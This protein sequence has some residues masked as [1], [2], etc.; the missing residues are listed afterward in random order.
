MADGVSPRVRRRTGEKGIAPA[1]AAGG[2]RFLVAAG[3][4]RQ[5]GGMSEALFVAVA[6]VDEIPPGKVKAVE[7]GGR[8][9]LLCHEEGRIHAIENRCSHAEM[10]L[11]CGRVRWGWISCPMH[12]ARFDLATGEAIK[13]PAVEPI[14]VFPVR[15]VGDAVEVAL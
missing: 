15:I 13:G 4:V 12:G 11:E 10:P 1:K 8:A 14:D 5:E 9:I 3:F 2:A 7:A 6:K